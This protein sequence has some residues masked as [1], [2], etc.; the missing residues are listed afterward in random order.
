[1]EAFRSISGMDNK[2]AYKNNNNKYNERTS[3][4]KIVHIYSWSAYKNKYIAI[5]WNNPAWRVGDI[6]CAKW[7]FS[8]NNKNSIN[9]HHQVKKACVLEWKIKM[10]IIVCN[11]N[12]KE[13]LKTYASSIEVFSILGAKMVH[14]F[15]E[16]LKL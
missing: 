5:I 12:K 4:D 6:K 7:H 13:T 1:M 2:I 14:I 8:N 15:I 3:S 16:L 9:R 11:T 10:C